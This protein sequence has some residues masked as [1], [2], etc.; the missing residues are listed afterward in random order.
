VRFEI[1]DD[2]EQGKTILD[3]VYNYNKGALDNLT[4]Q[5]P[6][7]KNSATTANYNVGAETKQIIDYQASIPVIYNISMEDIGGQRLFDQLLTLCHTNLVN[8]I[9]QLFFK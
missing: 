1:F 6:Q 5:L 9:N 7:I 4:E 8:R 3:E 2:R